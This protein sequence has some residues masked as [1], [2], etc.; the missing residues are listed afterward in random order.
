MRMYQFKKWLLQKFDPQACTSPLFLELEALEAR[1][2]NDPEIRRRN[3][4]ARAAYRSEMRP[5]AAVAVVLNLVLWA[6]VGYY[7]QALVPTWGAAAGGAVTSAM[8]WKLLQ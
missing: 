8:V 3:R 7:L 2:A 1:L 4:E 5:Y 6:A